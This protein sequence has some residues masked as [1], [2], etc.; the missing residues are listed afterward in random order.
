MQET[1]VWSLVQEGPTCCGA[2]KP[3]HLS[4]WAC[5]PE[6]RSCNCW[7]HVA[8]LPKPEHPRAR[9]MQQRV[10]LTQFSSGKALAARKTQH[11]QK[12]IKIIK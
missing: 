10:A 7:A 1:W 9:A 12:Q 3:A 8:Q 11:S 2:A 6:L 4:Y 5:V